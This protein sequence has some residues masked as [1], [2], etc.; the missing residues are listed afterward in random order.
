MPEPIP[1]SSK[2]ASAASAHAVWQGVLSGRYT[3]VNWYDRDGRRYLVTGRAP[4]PSPVA[5]TPRQRRALAMR[6]RGAAIKVIAGELGVSL[7][8]ISRDL[9]HAMQRLGL[10]S[11]ADL[12][13]VLGHVTG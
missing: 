12:A 1:P 11:S 6:A 2:A 5:V 8:T 3:I 13:A 9:T 4:D 10:A 7:G